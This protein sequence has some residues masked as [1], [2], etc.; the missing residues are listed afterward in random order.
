MR[1]SFHRHT[2]VFAGK[3]GV[4][5]SSTLNSLFGFSLATD[6]AVECTLT[7]AVRSIASADSSRLR[8]VDMPGIAANLTSARRFHSFYRH[9]LSRADILVWITQADV[10]AYKKDQQFFLDYLQFLKPSSQ[11]MVAIGK[12]DTLC[13]G[14]TEL[15]TPEQIAIVKSK[16]ADLRQQLDPY[17]GRRVDSV[18]YH[19]YSVFMGWNIGSLREAVALSEQPTNRTADLHSHE[20]L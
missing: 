18:R 10:R 11:L 6:A 13:P 4:G 12:F 8:V 3:R 2:V 17:L 16:I 20:V 5:K 14:I 9:W 1:L 15:Q 19:P 7:P